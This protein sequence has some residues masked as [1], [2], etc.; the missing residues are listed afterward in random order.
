MNFSQ[1]RD[2]LFSLRNKGSTFGIDRMATFIE[3]LGRPDKAYPIIHI[4]GTNGKGSTAAML[5]KIFRSAGYKTGLFTSPHLVFLGERIQVNRTS[6]TPE[7]ITSLIGDLDIHAKAIAGEGEENHPTFFEFMAAMAMVHFKN[8]AVDIAIIETGLGGRLDATNV[9][10][11]LISV[12]TS[13]GLD[14]TEILGDTIEKIAGEKAGIIKQNKPVVIGRVPDSAADVLINVAAEKNASVISVR[15]K[16]GDEV[17]AYP[18]TNLFGTFQRWNAATAITTCEY[19]EKSFPGLL[20]ISNSA[21]EQVDWPGRWQ[22]MI[23][24]CGRTVILDATHNS[25]GA[26]FL[27][28]NLGTLERELGQKPW[29]VVGTLGDLR[30]QYLIPAVARY[31][32]ALYFLEPKQPRAATFE[33]L[34]K[35]IPERSKC[36]S[37]NA[38][39][40]Q[41]FPDKETCSIGQPGDTI[42]VTGSIYLLGEVLERLTG[43]QKEIG[44]AL[45]DL[46]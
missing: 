19:L 21:L 24:P 43:Q 31:A 22:R 29:I 41:L 26:Q 34:Q 36:P 16:F 38:F 4:A 1:T 35:Y 20:E 32:R 37:E 23:L 30:A 15:Q 17:E 33:D 8:E 39:I 40:E 12:I 18:L 11:P 46:I 44:A 14:H 45:Q 9:V 6:I 2:Y 42:V 5:E 3:A 25:E 10:D 13:I 7:T 28:E 27:E